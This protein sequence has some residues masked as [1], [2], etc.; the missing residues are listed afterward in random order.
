MKRSPTSPPPAMDRRHFVKVSALAGGGL[1]I[2]T[3]VRLGHLEAAELSAA[4][5]DFAPNVFVSISPT[6]AVS[7][8][9]PNSEMGQGV[10]TSLPM[11]VAEE[12]DVAWQQVTITQGDLNPAYGRQFSVGSQSTPSNFMPLRRAGAVARAMLVEAAAE[13]WNVPAAECTTDRGV[14]I[15]AASKRRA[16]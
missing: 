2:G 3:Y 11:I 15:H 5:A 7:I 14:V 1:L 4:P 13:N 10:K 8:I 9:A 12:L 6:G 16:T